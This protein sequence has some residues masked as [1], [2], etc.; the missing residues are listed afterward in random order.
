MVNRDDRQCH[1]EGSNALCNSC[2]RHNENSELIPFVIYI[3]EPYDGFCEGYQGDYKP[4]PTKP[5]D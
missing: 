1:G 2:K 3:I 5:W 4:K